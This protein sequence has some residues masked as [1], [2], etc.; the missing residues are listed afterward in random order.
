MLRVLEASL[1]Q[2][3]FIISSNTFCQGKC[4]CT[5]YRFQYLNYFCAALLK[6]ER[7]LRGHSSSGNYKRKLDK[8][9]Q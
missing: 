8:V 9:F 6:G 4:D 7:V 2:L 5:K 1:L 3:L